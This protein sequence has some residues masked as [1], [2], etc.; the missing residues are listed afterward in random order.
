MYCDLKIK[1]TNTLKKMPINI[2]FF[3]YFCTRI[4]LSKQP[5]EDIVRLK[6]HHIFIKFHVESNGDVYLYVTADL[7]SE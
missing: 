2:N 6:M 3:F 7:K 4:Y 1:K 5:I